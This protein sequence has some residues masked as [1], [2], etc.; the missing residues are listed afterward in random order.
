[1]RQLLFLQNGLEKKHLN[2][3]RVQRIGS[4]LL[5]SLV[6]RGLGDGS[7]VHVQ[8]FEGVEIGFLDLDHVV[9]VA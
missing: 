7:A 8:S 3:Y 4:D 2:H 6:S 1:M 9:L 5:L